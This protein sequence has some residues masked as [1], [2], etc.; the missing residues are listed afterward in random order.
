MIGSTAESVPDL[1]YTPF[2]SGLADKQQMP[3][4]IVHAH[5]IGQLIRLALGQS[6]PIAFGN[7]AFEIFWIFA[8]A[9]AGAF[10]VRRIRSPWYVALIG[11]C[12]ACI[13]FA[14]TF[15]AFVSRW[16]IPVVPA[17]FAWFGSG[18]ILTAYLAN[19][20]AKQRRLLIAKQS[21]AR[22]RE[23]PTG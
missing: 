23:N 11:V 9:V 20:E 21:A 3:G 13:L 2:S 15:A 19:L 12:G 16:W 6:K 5:V 17:A 14:A 1:F 22:A 18:A 7:Q 8:W 10:A 4:V